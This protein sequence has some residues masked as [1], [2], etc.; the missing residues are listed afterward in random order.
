MT[1]ETS[2]K[3]RRAKK[4]VQLLSRMQD[5]IYSEL[6]ND[7]TIQI[8][9]GNINEEFLWDYVYNGERGES[10]EDYLSKY[11][12]ENSCQLTLNL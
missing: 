4:E 1:K 5:K 9:H 11:G 10:F 6:K 2:K 8:L 12:K 7:L 3:I